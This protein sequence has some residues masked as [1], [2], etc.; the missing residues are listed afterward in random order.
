MSNALLN[1]P[2]RS[3]MMLVDNTNT[4]V[5]GALF[6]EVE[7]VDP[8]NDAF[9]YVVV[10]KG[11]GVYEVRFT[12]TKVGVYTLLLVS[13]TTPPQWWITEVDVAG[14]V[15]GFVQTVVTNGRQFVNLIE[16][17]ATLCGDLM[18]A[19][20]TADGALDG[21]TWI[22]HFSLAAI[23]EKALKGSE[24]LCTSAS[25]DNLYAK[26]R[27][28]GST[29]GD[30]PT[31]TLVPTLPEQ[32]KKGDR[33]DVVNLQSLGWRISDYAR[34]VNMA[35]AAAYPNHL[36]GITYQ[37]PTNFDRSAPT[38]DVPTT[39]TVLARVEWQD[40][41]GL[42]QE[43]PRAADVGWNG[44]GWDFFAQRL[45]IGG[46]QRNWASGYPVRVGG[47]GK[48]APLVAMTDQTDCDPEWLALTA[49]SY[50]MRAKRDPKLLAVGSM[51][52]NQANFDRPK[53]VTQV[54]AD[55][56]VIR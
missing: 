36:A 20:A 3:T 16:D 46:E 52:L 15:P 27:I 14:V 13:N 32:V 7:N 1:Q 29:P 9:V 56:V 4:P 33:A 45:V 40:T 22:D 17:V 23:S 37:F 2:F 41:Q 26:A 48:Q 5:T 43:I 42:W 12:P 44:W 51:D 18:T 6:G 31:A 47:Y 28:L 21:S 54:E 30:P 39:F 34:F 38:L 53:M 10:E 19:E 35:L 55:S 11:G 49:S 8:D 25:G 50:A 24:L